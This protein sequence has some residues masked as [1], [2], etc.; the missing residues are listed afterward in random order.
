MLLLGEYFPTLR[1]T[2]IPS[3]SGSKILLL[4]LL[5]P[6]HE[7]TTIVRNVENYLPD[8]WNITEDLNL[9]QRR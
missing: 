3:L 8:K 5:S 1:W 4:G 7:G 2:T 9:L 6:E